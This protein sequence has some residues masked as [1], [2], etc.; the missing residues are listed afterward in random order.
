MV[1]GRYF[2]QEFPTDADQAFIL[3]EAAVAYMGLQSPLGQRIHCPLPFDGDRSGLIVGVV[4][5]FHF[6]SLHEEIQPLIL[7]VA[8]GWFTDMYIRIYPNNLKET[9]GFL[10]ST[11]KELAPDFPLNYTFLNED[12]DRLYKEDRRIGSLVRY[13]AALA[14]LI[15]G[16]GLFGLASF[17]AEQ[18]TKEIG[19]RKVLGASISEIVFLLTREFSRWVFLANLIAWPLAYLAVTAWLKSFAY[20]IDVQIFVFL[21]VGLA[22]LALSLI[23]VSYQSVRAARANPVDSLRYE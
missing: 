22:A 3:N 2:S 9:M 5:D 19:V 21:L 6:R 23:S 7:A 8:P 16:L 12:I 10:E 17:T 11:L 1:Q 4:K 15:A 13:G 18:R 20:R 14:V